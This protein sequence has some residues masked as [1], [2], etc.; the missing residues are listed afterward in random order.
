MSEYLLPLVDRREIADGTM[1][2][3][4]DTTGTDFLFTAG[5]YA[6][7]TLPNF[8]EQ[9]L[10]GFTP[11]TD[12][13]GNKR[14]FSIVSS[15]SELSPNKSSEDKPHKFPHI[16]IATRMFTLPKPGEGRRDTAFKRN[17][18]N[19]PLGTKIR[20]SAPMGSFVLHPHTH[21]VGVGVN[22][23]ADR[24][25]LFLVGGIGITPIRS[26][27]AD[28]THRKLPHKLMLIYSN[29]TVASTAF[30]AEFEEWAKENQNFLFIPTITDSP[31]SVSPGEIVAGG[32][33]K[34]WTHEV[35]RITEP[36]LRTHLNRLLSPTVPNSYSLSPIAYLVGPPAFVSAMLP[37]AEHV[38]IDPDNI[39][40]EEFAGY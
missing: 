11:E 28:A 39:R 40:T 16:M 36:M 21:A 27:I 38:G 10:G 17:L 33:P 32:Q 15:P 3:W 25:A 2:F 29:R 26:I 5:Q 8:G 31:A 1:A 24:P 6:S 30:L 13:E 7:F 37:I 18:R 20:I 14:D 34:G 35:G 22:K 12:A 4:F 23:N 19:M 9:N